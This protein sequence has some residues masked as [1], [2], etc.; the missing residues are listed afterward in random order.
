MRTPGA[1]TVI[2]THVSVLHLHDDV[3]VKFKKPV[4]LPFLDFTSSEAR[5][6][7]CEEEVAANRRL[8]PDVYLGVAALRLDAEVLDHAVV[9]RRLPADR[10]LAA[11]VQRSEAGALHEDLV[12]LGRVLA[13]F[14]DRA[15]RSAVI[16]AE[17]RPE[18]LRLTWRRCLDTLA[19]FAGRLVDADVLARIDELAMRYLTGRAPL[20]ERRIS[21]GRICDGHGD[22]LADDVFL[23]DDGP[24]L[25]DCVEFDRRLRYVDV[26]ADVAFL[27]MDLE[28]L[29]AQRSAGELLAAYEEAAGERIVP[30]L[31]H[32]YVAER[33]TVR[34]EVACLRAEQSGDAVDGR[35]RAGALAALALEHLEAGRVVCGVVSGLPGTGKS[36]VAR[37]AG[38][39]LDWP[40]F[41]SDEIRRDLV[42]P[43]W[44]GPLRVDSLP[45]AYG[46]DVTAHTYAILLARAR[47]ALGQGRSVL[48]DATFAGPRWRSAVVQLARETASDL[49]ALSCEAPTDVAAARLATRLA[50]GRDLSGADEAVARAMAAG[51]VPWAEAMPLDTDRPLDAVVGEAIGLLRGAPNTTPRRQW[52]QGRRS[53]AKRRA[54]TA[55]PARPTAAR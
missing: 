7:A 33:A 55:S 41:S 16:D 42:A 51:T 2:E 28:R 18:A 31:L 8:S 27:V 26:A 34:A 50:D 10:S 37:A 39:A 1:A 22:L 38:T 20:F 46:D 24:R 49:V 9:M 12:R 36:S 13:R 3:V 14:H 44:R 54:V 21:E 17:A 29:G 11:V 40:V 43:G 30:S 48:L 5:R 45:G 19:P 23:L 32:H 15:E 25:L 53:W 6:I 4:R 52:R 35:C 47:A